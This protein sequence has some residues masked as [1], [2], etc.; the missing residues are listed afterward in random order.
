MRTIAHALF[1]SAAALALAACGSSDS[2]SELAEP[3]NVELPAEEAMS[4]VDAGAAPTTA[5]PGASDVASDAVASDAAAQATATP[6]PAPA[7]AP[8][9][10]PAKD[11]APKQ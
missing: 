1:T 2:A 6:A 3:E 4:N 7:P 9:A 8:A 11:A 10:A 5:T